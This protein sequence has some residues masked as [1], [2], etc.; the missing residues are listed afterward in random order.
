M[1]GDAVAQAALL[2]VLRVR[3]RCRLLLQLLQFFLQVG[4]ASHQRAN[5]L[6]LGGLLLHFGPARVGVL[7]ISR[8]VGFRIENPLQRQ[9]VQRPVIFREIENAI[10]RLEIEIR[11]IQLVAMPQPAGESLL[12][13]LRVENLALE[14][15]DRGFLR[16]RRH[17]NAG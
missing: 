6:V 15:V 7:L 8:L 11:A 1:L 14:I 2:F 17:G 16:A 4:Q 5:G 3:R 12:R 10:A 13:H 9:I